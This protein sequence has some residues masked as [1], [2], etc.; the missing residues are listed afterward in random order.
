MNG[1]HNFD[2]GGYL[3][4]AGTTYGD[5]NGD[6][7]DEAVVDLRYGTGGTATW[8]FLYVY[9]LEGN[10]PKLIAMM[11][12]GS[13]AFGGLEAVKIEKSLLVL[14][15]ADSELR[16]GDCCSGGFVRVQYRWHG[17]RFRETG[18]RTKGALIKN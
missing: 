11:E 2:K 12:C 7:Q 1:R 10:Q 4:L 17:N 9:T 16:Q 13:R 3:V 18:S 15:F 14:D 5:L 8:H 6:K